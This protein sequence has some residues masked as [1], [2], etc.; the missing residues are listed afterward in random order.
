MPMFLD[1]MD[2]TFRLLMRRLRK[3]DIKV[4]FQLLEGLSGLALG[5]EK[6]TKGAIS[7]D[8]VCHSP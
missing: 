1:K 5:A 2:Q 6:S 8:S 3:P 7:G 4:I